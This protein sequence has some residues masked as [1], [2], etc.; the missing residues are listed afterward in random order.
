MPLIGDRNSNQRLCKRPAN[1]LGIVVQEF[2]GHPRL[3]E[4][5]V[6]GTARST[7]STE[8]MP[9]T[10]EMSTVSII[11]Q[12]GKPRS[13]MTSVLVWRTR[14]KSALMCGLRI[15]VFHIGSPRYYRSRVT[16]KSARPCKDSL[17]GVGARRS[18][19]P[20]RPASVENRL[21]PGV[22]DRIAAFE[23]G[24]QRP[25]VMIARAAQHG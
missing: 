11:G 20:R 24:R 23:P 12:K 14:L 6:R 25:R 7:S 4:D 2:L 21:L 15:P 18:S 9:S 17:A 1:F 8:G 22:G 5:K 13:A 10:R 3:A 16:T 19:S